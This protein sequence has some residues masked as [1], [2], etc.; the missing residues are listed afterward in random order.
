MGSVVCIDNIL[1]VLMLGQ[2]FQNVSV[3]RRDNHFL[4]V[5]LWHSFI[6]FAVHGSQACFA[7]IPPLI[8]ILGSRLAEYTPR[9]WLTTS[10]ALTFILTSTLVISDWQFAEYYR[11]QAK[12]IKGSLHT[13]NTVW[14][15]GHWGW[16]WYA[17]R[18]GLKQLESLTP[19]AVPG[20]LLI[21][22]TGIHQQKINPD[23]VMSLQGEITGSK[24]WLPIDSKA[25]YFSS[26]GT[27]PWHLSKGLG[28]N[29]YI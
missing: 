17:K 4:L 12:T 18:N 14:F 10:I 29:S 19:Q 26:Y 2:R 9:I 7:V 27:I 11:Q 8:L 5:D 23:L 13:D 15:T 28:E 3:F 25:I 1:V 22:P 20:D 6:F 16:Q 24:S 21:Y